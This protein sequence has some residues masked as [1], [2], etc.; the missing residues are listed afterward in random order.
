M[1]KT[2]RRLLP[3][4]GTLS[5]LV[6]AAPVA[7][8]TADEGRLFVRGY[9]GVSFASVSASD[10]VDAVVAGGGVGVNLSRHFAVIGDV[11]Y[12]TNLAREDAEASLKHIVSL[13]TLVSGADAEVS[14]EAR[15]LYVLGGG[16]FTMGS[17]RVRTFVEGQGGMVRTSYTLKIGNATGSVV[18]DANSIFKSLIGDTTATAPAAGAGGGADIRLSHSLSAEAAYHYLRLF[19]DAKS[20][21]H[22]V[23]GGLKLTF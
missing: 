13:I 7:A 16:R 18:T 4:A 12:I 3:L 15:T 23:T 22:Q 1:P 10:R 11:G 8:Q 20:N 9:G 17:G 2:W 5:I 21:I 19:G 6:S 14:L